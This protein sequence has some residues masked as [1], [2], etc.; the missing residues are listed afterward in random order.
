MPAANMKKNP[1]AAAQTFIIDC[2]KP[3]DDG[4]MEAPTFVRRAPTS[5]SIQRGG[6]RGGGGAPW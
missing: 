4:L 5:T 3:V 1:K 2:T 6:G